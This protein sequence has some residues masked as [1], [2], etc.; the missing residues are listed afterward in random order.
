MTT[1]RFAIVGAGL[2]A[3]FH[4]RAIRDIPNTALVAV[5]DNVPEKARALAEK[6][7]AKPFTSYEQMVKSDDVDIVTIAT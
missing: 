1:H 2:I 5:C 3:D 7:G 6:Y 4:A